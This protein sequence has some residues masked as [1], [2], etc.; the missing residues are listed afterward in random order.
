VTWT[1]HLQIY[2]GVVTALAALSGAVVAFVGLFTWKTQAGWNEDTGLSR[3]LLVA[4]Y[5]YRDAFNDAR[6]RLIL[7]E[8]GLPEAGMGDAPGTSPEAHHA[9]LQRALTRRWRRVEECRRQVYPLILE[10]R[11]Q[12]GQA[13]AGLWSRLDE[14]HDDILRDLEL[15]LEAEDPKN[16]HV[17]AAAIFGVAEGKEKARLKLFQPYRAG[18]VD[19]LRRT[20]DQTF[21]QMETY[22]RG[23]IGRRGR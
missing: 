19:E 20:F 9:W 10:A 12:W 21:A 8:E 2:A 6:R 17:D 16:R 4:L 7:A 18:E 14:L 5:L 13:L 11:A 22:L 23:K 15:Y 1:D 3:R